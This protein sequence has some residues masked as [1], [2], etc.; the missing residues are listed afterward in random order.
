[1]AKVFITQHQDG[2][3]YVQVNNPEK[4]G[5]VLSADSRTLQINVDGACLMYVQNIGELVLRDGRTGV[6][7]IRNMVLSDNDS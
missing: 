4:L 7:I 5:I 1:M 3:E 6:D 2:H